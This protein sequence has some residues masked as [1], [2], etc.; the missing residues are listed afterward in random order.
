MTPMAAHTLVNGD[1]IVT[2]ADPGARYTVVAV[3]E[4]KAWIR[5]LTGQS[6]MIVEH[7]RCSPVRLLN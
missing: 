5:G 7:H 4:R 1:E 3:H 2:D 6:E